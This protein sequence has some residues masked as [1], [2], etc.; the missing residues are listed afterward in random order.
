MQRLAAANQH[1]IQRAQTDAGRQTHRRRHAERAR[2]RDDERRHTDDESVRQRRLRAEIVPGDKAENREDH[3]GGRKVTRNDIHDP[4]NGHLRS[5]RVLH[6]AD[7]VRQRGVLADLGRAELERAGLVDRRADHLVADFFLDRHALAGHHRF[8]YRTG[9][10]QHDAVYR[11]LFAGTDE[12]GIADQN[13]LDGKIHFLA[14]P[15]DTRRLW[16]QADQFLDRLTRASFR[17]HFHRQAEDDETGHDDGHVIVDIHE[18]FR[19]KDLREQ[20][21]DA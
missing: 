13:L 2:A 5:L 11:N 10:V 20:K 1:P 12:H 17:L 16:L 19:R 6:H 14:I 18:F 9:A 15:N 4:L 8:V 3:H 7:D 21:R